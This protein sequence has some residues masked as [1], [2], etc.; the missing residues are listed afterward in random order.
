MIPAI[1]KRGM[2]Y[3][4][5]CITAGVVRANPEPKPRFGILK[6]FATPILIGINND[7]APTSG[8]IL[9]KSCLREV[10]SLA[11]L[12]LLVIGGGSLS[13][14]FVRSIS[15]FLPFFSIE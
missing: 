8:I 13:S 4:N 6:T 5:P 9:L 11:V 10:L 15:Y 7:C 12:L 2:V 14:S 3:C 1:A